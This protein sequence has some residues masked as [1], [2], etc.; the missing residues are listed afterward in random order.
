[1]RWPSVA[2][3]IGALRGSSPAARQAALADAIRAATPEEAELLAPEL[4]EIAAAFPPDPGGASLLHAWRARG[5]RQRAE[6]ADAALVALLRA[7]SKLPAP[8]RRALPGVA[9]GR[10][11]SIPRSSLE[12]ATAAEW[13]SVADAV[14]TLD[15]RPACALLVGALLAGD[16]AA[17][18]AERALSRIVAR[19]D[20][21]LRESP[22][23]ERERVA[24]EGCLAPVA[25]AV[26]TALETL[27]E[28]KRRRVGDAAARLLI[29]PGRALVR[30]PEAARALAAIAELARRAD[31]PAGVAI[32]GAIRHDA[33]P[34]ARERAWVLLRDRAFAAPALDRLHHA[35]DDAEHVG[36]LRRAHLALHPRRPA[37]L[38]AVRAKGAG[39]RPVIDWPSPDLLARLDPEARAGFVRLVA[40]LEPRSGT[41]DGLLSPLVADEDAG[42]RLRVVGVAGSAE[43]EDYL[44]DAAR[45]VARGAAWRWS[46]VGESAGLGAGAMDRRARLARRL[47]RAA[48]PVMRAFGDDERARGDELDP[49]AHG[50]LLARR[51]WA[52]DR[53][54]VLARW[55]EW[56]RAG[57]GGDAASE[58][59]GV[60]AIGALRAVLGE[61][62]ASDLLL[63]VAE[64]LQGS[65]QG[66]LAATVASA[67]A[68]V[69]SASAAA[70]LASW[71]EQSPDHRVRAN[72]MEAL[73]RRARLGV[74]AGE[75][76]GWGAAWRDRVVELRADA[77]HRVR[78]GAVRVMLRESPGGSGGEG[79][80]GALVSMLEDARAGHRLAGVWAAERALLGLDGERLGGAM[81]GVAARLQGLAEGDEDGTVRARAERVATLAT[82]G[83]RAGWGESVR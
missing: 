15:G 80:I 72:A 18:A 78:G 25:R 19:L 35:E 39:A 42:V 62:D 13:A 75:R 48:E 16:E 17:T 31:H 47:C 28:H 70:R 66:R 55:G 1:M 59:R 81:A 37:H 71:V 2:E 73:I 60:R 77:G 52:A 61:A 20:R 76:G 32:R 11:G 8:V 83:V 41:R 69:P 43:L 68:R 74:G 58:L 51:R 26:A 64:R 34:A 49:S 12:G 40:M 38:G 79:G 5:D 54:G 3:A 82:R 46:T 24:A 67:L 4:L 56:I 30:D 57:V 21:E 9:D 45:P 7:W 65:A 6:A 22:A 50:R 10:W 63:D 33:D 53:A 29:A 23:H 27:G 14:G 44:F 36:L